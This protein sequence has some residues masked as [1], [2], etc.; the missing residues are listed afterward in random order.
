MSEEKRRYFLSLNVEHTSDSVL[1]DALRD[2]MSQFLGTEGGKVLFMNKGPVEDK[3][4]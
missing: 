1:D 3:K 4:S 2:F